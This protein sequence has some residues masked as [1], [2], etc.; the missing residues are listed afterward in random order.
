LKQFLCWGKFGRLL[1]VAFGTIASACS[2]QIRN[3][4]KSISLLTHPTLQATPTQLAFTVQPT[5]IE[6]SGSL[7]VQPSIEIQDS[8]GNLFNS[9]NNPI[10][11]EAFTDS[12]CTVAATGAL[13]AMS[14]PMTASSGSATFAG[15]TY[16]G[17][18]RS[19]IYIKASS[20]GLTSA[21][22]AAVTTDFRM[23]VAGQGGHACA[24]SNLGNVYCWG[25]N[26]NGETGSGIL[27]TPDSPM[28]VLG[29]GGT[30]FLSDII[31]ISAASYNT[32]A[33][34]NSGNVYC[35]GYNAD[36]ELG[37][38]TTVNSPTPVEVVGVGGSGFL[39]NITAIGGNCAVSS[40]GN[41][42]CWGYNNAGE[43]GNNSTTNSSTPVE[44]VG[45]GGVGF[46]SGV[47]SISATWFYT[48]CAI[49]TSGNAYC[50][51]Y[52]NYGQLGNNSTT[53]SS[54]PVE[55]MGVGGTGFLSGLNSISAGSYTTCASTTAGNAYCWGRGNSGQLG[56]NTI[57]ISH[58][59]VEVSGV[60]GSGVLSGV[61]SV[62]VGAFTSC[63]A[64]MSG[65]YCWGDNSDG[66]L[67]NNS[68]TNSSTPV[69]S[70]GVGGSGVLSETISVSSGSGVVCSASGAGN[71]YC[72]GYSQQGQLGN[73]DAAQVANPT[74]VEVFAVN[75]NTTPLS[76][77]QSI[78]NGTE[79]NCAVTN[80]GN[81]YCWGENDYGALGNNTTISSSTP[82]EVLGVGGVGHLSNIAS[83]S[84]SYETT[85][86][87]LTS[88]NVYCWGANDRGQLGINSSLITT[89][90]TPVEVGG[91]GGTGV[92][93]NI[94]AISR[95]EY[96]SCALSSG[97]NVY[98]WGWNNYG[99]IGNN[100][101]TNAIAP[102]E[103]F[104]TNGVDFL[105]NITA[106]SSGVYDTCA[107]SLAGNAYCWG[108]NSYGQVGNNSGTNV[109]IP[110]KVSDP[111]G[112]G[113]LS[114]VVSIGSNGAITCASD[115]S[116]S[117]YCWGPNIVGSLG[118]NSGSNS[119]IPVQVFGVGGSGFLSNIASISGASCA[120]S[121][122][123]NEY[124]W[125][126]NSSGGLGNNSTVTSYV[127]VEVLG[128]GGSG[129]LS[130]IT[131]F[132]QSEGG[133]CAL[134]TAGT[135]AC[136]GENLWGALG[137]GTSDLFNP[138][139]IPIVV[140]GP[141]SGGFLQL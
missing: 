16:N 90:L 75:T 63:A 9:A 39:S 3:E 113:F 30:G 111:S 45:V 62:S 126:G 124:C 109:S 127:P 114:N 49:V 106:I 43:L 133:G 72:S 46:L 107:I 60:G 25:S 81:A 59:P 94:T 65:T 108:S 135:V 48:T 5:L 31:A 88:G 41:A 118:N 67:G 96:S 103:V 84:T 12:G 23:V 121:T 132:S 74:P 79:T 110:V 34:S 105:S 20:A 92:L 76:N 28:E 21:C 4:L 1:I 50:W 139:G 125:G 42:Y 10:T 97:G 61:T 56:N 98:C 35:W 87:L 14:N 101:T 141:H 53:S 138:E 58:T 93:S 99:E 38:N 19:T 64:S 40:A 52:N 100:T 104:D 7:L 13:G 91:V 70:M 68:E 102:V 69:Q 136:W 18:A 128:V 82:I 122:S 134:S 33:L 8:A 26:S 95:N 54:T 44:V 83:I 2:P 66:Q 80:S 116:G 78:S 131:A 27:A 29:V 32:C 36:G 137:N 24:L 17:A 37:N 140:P 119:S 130:N 73:N 85:C 112:V 77:I 47:V 71:V 123:G 22:S 6:S 15:L 86:A 55:V 120:L 51:G 89:S 11:L 129:F 117:A 57:S 115:S